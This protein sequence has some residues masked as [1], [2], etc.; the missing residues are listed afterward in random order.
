LAQGNN[1]C[2]KLRQLRLGTDNPNITFT[3]IF[4][5]TDSNTPGTYAA[6][7]YDETYTCKI[8]NYTYNSENSILPTYTVAFQTA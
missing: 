8:V 1:F 7:G 2:K 6:A 5:F 4:N 3:V